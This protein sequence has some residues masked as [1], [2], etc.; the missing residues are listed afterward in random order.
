V[1]EK[2]YDRIF[3]SFKGIEDDLL[4]LL[5]RIQEADG[6]ISQESVRRVSH[7]L[8]MSENKIYGVASFYAKY[9]FTKPGRNTIKVCMGT[10]CH[11]RG[12]RSLVD[13]V[14]WQLGINMGQVTPDG[15][16]DFQRVTCLG[17]CTL[18]P[19]VQ[20]NEDIHDRVMVLGLKETLKKYE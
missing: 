18:A 14:G 7:F 11:V 12:G 6:Y 1:K 8:K 19:V 10:A 20:I 17:C 5:L 2:D 9:R 16:F 13:A 3:S 15:R 4:P